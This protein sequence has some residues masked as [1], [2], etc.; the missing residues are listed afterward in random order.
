MDYNTP[1]EGIG[2]NS[3]DPVAIA[4]EDAERALRAHTAR[5]D[6]LIEAAELYPDDFRD[7]EMAEKATDLIAMMKTLDEDAAA[8]TKR[9]KDPFL[10]AQRAVVEV[11]T[12]WLSGIQRHYER[13][14]A[15]LTAWSLS[16]KGRI[17]TA[18]KA[19]RQAMAD[20]PEPSYVSHDSLDKM[21]V[22]GVRGT[23]GARAYLRSNVVITGVRV[24]MLPFEFLRRPAIMEAIEAEAKYLIRHHETVPGVTHTI[25]AKA[26]VRNK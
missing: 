12:T 7:L 18:R 22:T 4:R 25:E 11:S 23:M 3:R 20:D 10:N 21:V 6:S 13:L 15:A 17:A 2:H 5:R 19:Q 26:Q 8:D 9:I 16:D 1:S 14:N 24:P